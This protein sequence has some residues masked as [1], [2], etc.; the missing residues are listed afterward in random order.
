M[1]KNK[2][3]TRRAVSY[4]ITNA[5]DQAHRFCSKILLSTAICAAPALT[6]ACIGMG[7]MLTGG[8]SQQASP[9]AVPLH[10]PGATNETRGTRGA[11]ATAADPRLRLDDIEPRSQIGGRGQSLTDYGLEP[12]ARATPRPIRRLAARDEG[13]P[14]LNPLAPAQ[15][16]VFFR[17][18]N[19]NTWRTRIPAAS[20]YPIIVRHLSESYVIRNSDA[21]SMS[22]QTDWDKFFIGGRLFRNRL[23]ISLFQLA[24]LECEMVVN[25]KVEYFQASEE[26]SAYGES[27][28]IP[29][30]DVTNEKKQLL[31]ALSRILHAMN[32]ASRS[33]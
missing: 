3:I 14:G 19:P 9:Y 17:P 4:L 10:G 33:P 25:N 30:Q 22:I 13:I 12:D 8:T 24:G 1:E 5:A 28:W 20:L 31:E 11:L 26:N 2:N 23:N 32:V 7:G 6:C 16:P 21:R 27:D 18:I 29:T 15:P